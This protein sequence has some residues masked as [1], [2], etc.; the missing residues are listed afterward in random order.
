[1]VK[2]VAENKERRRSWAVLGRVACSSG[3]A[4]STS[5]AQALLFIQLV[6][7]EHT[8]VIC[9]NNIPGHA[10]RGTY[11][12]FYRLRSVRRVR[13]GM[14]EPWTY[15][16]VCPTECGIPSPL[17]RRSAAK[18]RTK[19]TWQ[20]EHFPW[21]TAFLTREM[22]RLLRVLR[23]ERRMPIAGGRSGYGSSSSP[24]ARFSMAKSL[25]SR[26]I[27]SRS[28]ENPSKTLI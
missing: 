28:V 11:P 26:N 20:T 5:A 17:E 27:G 24:I 12:S 21:N 9:L 4:R 10:N 23:I 22:S 7:T 19:K 8:R 18:A 15:T 2:R 3:P 1:M 25:I 6:T 13:K 14:G 16:R